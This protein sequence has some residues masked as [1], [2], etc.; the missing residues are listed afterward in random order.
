MEFE[1]GKKEGLS[2]MVRKIQ[3]GSMEKRM[4]VCSV[5]AYLMAIDVLH[6]IMTIITYFYH[7]PAKL[8][9]LIGLL[10]EAITLLTLHRWLT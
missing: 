3:M 5:F 4:R 9:H 8:D 10:W 6:G 7:C 1:R 2:P